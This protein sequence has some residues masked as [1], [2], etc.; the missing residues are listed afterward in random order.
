VRYVLLC[1]HGTHLDGALTTATRDGRI[2]Y[3]IHAV[4]G[5]LAGELV[6]IN[7]PGR[8]P[9]RLAAVRHSCRPEATETLQKLLERLPLAVHGAHAI[10]VDGRRI[11]IESTAMLD[12]AGD[13]SAGEI[14][15]AASDLLAAAGSLGGNAVLV[16]GHQPALSRIA[17]SLLRRG[18][19]WWRTSRSPTPVDRSGIVCVAAPGTDSRPGAWIAWAISYDDDAAGAAVRDK[20]ARKMETAKSFGGLLTVAL[21]I[22]LGVLVEGPDFGDRHW[23]VQLSAVLYLIASAL[24]VVT[25]FHY[26]SLLMPARFWGES[27][28]GRR[29]RWLVERPPSSDAW[30]LYQNMT[31]IWRNLF[32]VASVLA[33]AATALFASAAL[34]IRGWVAVVSALAAL[35]TVWWLY[36][37]RPLLGSED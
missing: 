5:R 3:P 1:R 16:V 8:P 2:E 26:D 6:R 33:F 29:P 37:S 10:T 20:I 14:D 35:L 34:D 15:A 17:D 21:T 30:V 32:T 11:G 28:S 31:R 36:R 22:V 4:A 13:P 7:P 24:Y 18:R 23:Q 25:M 12:G 19:R 27:G 9:I